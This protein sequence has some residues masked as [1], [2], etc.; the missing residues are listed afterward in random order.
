[1]CYKLFFSKCHRDETL[2]DLNQSKFDM[3]CRDDD[4]ICVCVCVRD[5]IPHIK[6]EK[7]SEEATNFQKILL[8]RTASSSVS[9]A[10][11]TLS[12]TTTAAFFAV[13]V[14]PTHPPKFH[15]I[16]SSDTNHLTVFRKSSVTSEIFKRERERVEKWHF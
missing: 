7:H 9:E 1:M 8:S 3:M 5:R 4:E 13:Q 12:T 16:R 15:C 10:S 11:D 2:N 6:K 14:S